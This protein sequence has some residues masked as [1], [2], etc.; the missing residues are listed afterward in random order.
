[1]LESKP[2]EFLRQHVHHLAL[3][4]TI[5]RPDV[6]RVL[7]TCTN[8][9]DLTIWTGDT[10]PELLPLLCKMTNLK[11]LST[12]LRSLLEGQD[13]VPL[14]IPLPAALPFANLTHL[15]IFSDVPERIWPVFGMLPRLT[16]LAFTDN[17]M[18]AMIH[19]A[20]DACALLQLV[21]V[22]WTMEEE[23]AQFPDESKITDPRFCVVSCRLFEDDWLIGA[24][25]GDDFWRRGEEL[26]ADRIR[27]QQEGSQNFSQLT[28]SV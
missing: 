1:M 3:S 16:H 5:P 15:D 21:V 19:A 25:G 2:A 20:L 23:D 9:Q 18:P 26:V 28:I 11:H 27:A 14:R 24:V 7:S 8:V 10:Y 6:E 17:F 4:T 13:D 22:A 12:N